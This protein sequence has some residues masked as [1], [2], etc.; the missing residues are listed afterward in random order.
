MD[1]SIFEGE[2][3]GVLAITK[4]KFEQGFKIEKKKNCARPKCQKI[5]VQRQKLIRGLK[6]VN[7][8]ML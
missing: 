6:R 2:G 3:R 7:S 1:H 4:K 5:F 8:S